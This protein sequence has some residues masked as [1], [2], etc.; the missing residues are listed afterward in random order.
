[1]EYERIHSW[2]VYVSCVS[3]FTSLDNCNAML[4]IQNLVQ[5]ELA[6]TTGS[7]S[8]FST[9]ESIF[10]RVIAT[11]VNNLVADMHQS[12]RKYW[13]PEL[14]ACV[15]PHHFPMML[16]CQ[17]SRRGHKTSSQR[18]NYSLFFTEIMLSE[19][20]NINLVIL[21]QLWAISYITPSVELLLCH[22]SI[23]DNAHQITT[24]S[25]L[26]L[27]LLS[28]DKPKTEKQACSVLWIAIM[29]LNA[30][31]QLWCHGQ[32][33]QQE[34]VSHEGQ[35]SQHCQVFKPAQVSQHGYCSTYDNLVRPCE[36]PCRAT[37]AHLPQETQATPHAGTLPM[38]LLEKSQGSIRR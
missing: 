17:R 10:G 35:A 19:W 13:F 9:T 8:V 1:M 25:A 30:N 22:S 31:W 11:E 33:S 7:E 12:Y 32:M 3:R 4:S 34:R 16:S 37:R 29:P 23:K 15:L 28:D 18:N 26:S 6:V 20:H 24:L 27:H 21:R 5:L 38:V 14:F 36:T 2:E